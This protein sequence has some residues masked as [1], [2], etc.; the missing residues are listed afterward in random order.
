MYDPEEFGRQREDLFN[1]MSQNAKLRKETYDAN[2]QV[3]KQNWDAYND[4]FQEISKLNQELT[5]LEYGESEKRAAASQKGDYYATPMPVQQ[6]IEQ[7]RIRIRDVKNV[8]YQPAGME[9]AAPAGVPTPGTPTAVGAYGQPAGTGTD[10][11]YREPVSALPG[12]VGDYGEPMAQPL[13][14]TAAGAAIPDIGMGGVIEGAYTGDVLPGTVQPAQ[15]ITPRGGYSYTPPGMPMGGLAAPYR[16]ETGGTVTGEIP[17]GGLETYEG[18]PGVQTPGGRGFATYYDLYQGMGGGQ[19]TPWSAEQIHEG[20]FKNKYASPAT[21]LREFFN[22]M[23][24]FASG[25]TGRN[26]MYRG[27]MTQRADLGQGIQDYQVRRDAYGNIRSYTPGGR[28]N[29]PWNPYTSRYD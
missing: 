21:S 22:P 3:A 13:Q 23:R 7:L 16:G 12:I 18:L 6:K 15:A 10:L 2:A 27:L 14:P 4:Y 26:A 29:Q 20:I 5:D 1:Y 8:S 28:K 17:G 25:R 9:Q 24:G 11:G 19:T